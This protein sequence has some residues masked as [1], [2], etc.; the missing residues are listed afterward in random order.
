[1][2][3]TGRCPPP[4]QY[5]ISDRSRFDDEDRPTTVPGLIC[6][7]EEENRSIR[8][9]ILAEENHRSRKHRKGQGLGIKQKYCTYRPFILFIRGYIRLIQA[10]ILLMLE[11][12]LFI[13]SYK[14]MS[15]IVLQTYRKTLSLITPT[16][17]FS[18][19]GFS[20]Q[21]QLLFAANT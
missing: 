13:A 2:W 17:C 21:N 19:I 7:S 6:D 18:Y 3:K 5:S 15:C 9:G 12:S 8:A 16:Q 4:C 20:T 14:F 1:M 10:C 11:I